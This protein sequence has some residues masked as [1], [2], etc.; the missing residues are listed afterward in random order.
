MPKKMKEDLHGKIYNKVEERSYKEEMMKRHQ[1][2]EILE[3][4]AR[5]Y[6]YDV[7]K[8]QPHYNNGEIDVDYLQAY[9]AECRAKEEQEAKSKALAK[10]K[11]ALKGKVTA[12]TKKAPGPPKQLTVETENKLPVAIE[13]MGKSDK[14]IDAPQ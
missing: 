9:V 4:F 5:V 2:R 7:K 8:H 14:M 11:E 13:A 12:V 10:Q 3:E 1:E 6:G